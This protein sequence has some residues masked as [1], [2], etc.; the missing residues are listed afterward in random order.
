M[1]MSVCV[2]IIHQSM[3]DSIACL[4]LLMT[5]VG[6]GGWGGLSFVGL[7]SY[8]SG[9]DFRFQVHSEQF[10]AAFGGGGG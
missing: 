5:E 7:H 9:L 1:E 2:F 8:A 3:D 4:S 6:V 10:E